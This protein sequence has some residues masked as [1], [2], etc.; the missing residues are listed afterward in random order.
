MTYWFYELRS[1]IRKKRF[2]LRIVLLLFILLF[3][4]SNAFILISKDYPEVT[5]S[6]NTFISNSNYKALSVF[7]FN[8]DEKETNIGSSTEDTEANE[9]SAL[10]FFE[11]LFKD[12]NTSFLTG[13]VEDLYKYYTLKDSGGRYSLQHE[14]KRVAYLRDWSNT[15]NITFTSVTSYP[16]LKYIRGGPNTYSARVDEEYK[17]EYVYNDEPE[18]TNQCGVSLFHTLT[19]QKKDDSFLICKDYYLDCFEDGLKKYFFNLDEK[20]LPITTEA[21]Y[22]INFAGNN[23]INITDK[24]DRKACLEYAD[25]YCGI[26]WA[27]NNPQKYNKKYLNFTGSGGN[28]T[29]YVSQCLADKEGG[30]MKTDGSWHFVQKKQ[31]GSVAWLNADGFKNY[32]LYTGKG[33][34][35]KHGNFEKL[36]AAPTDGNPH[37]FEQLQVGDIV[38]YDN[39]GD[40]DHNVIITG[41]DS[42]GYPLVNSHTVDR[43]RTPFD[44]GWGDDNFKFYLIHINS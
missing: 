6:T 8:S 30:R 29:N 42:K 40:I 9:A 22:Q 25:K 43:Y 28:C 21:K 24:L 39:K 31:E 33:K 19:L 32:I 18:V 36:Y 16:K 34:V 41:F 17:F 26:T 23:N 12:R 14:F 7:K 5:N 11:S 20:E 44:F 2:T 38:S 15:R 13:N 4:L 27:S 10:Q 37:I 35:L 1:F 3:F